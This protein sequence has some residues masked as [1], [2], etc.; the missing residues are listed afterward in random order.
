M[1]VTVVATAS[2]TNAEYLPGRIRI[3]TATQ[4]GDFIVYGEKISNPDYANGQPLPNPEPLVVKTPAGFTPIHSIGQEP[5]LT[6]YFSWFWKIAE[7]GDAGAWLND[8]PGGITT[9]THSNRRVMAV[10]RADQPITGAQ[11]VAVAPSFSEGDPAQIALP[12]QGQSLAIALYGAMGGTVNPRIANVAPSVEVTVPSNS[13]VY[14][15][16]WLNP[17]DNLTLDIDDEGTWNAVM[18]AVVTFGEVVTVPVLIPTLVYREELN[19]VP[20]G[21]FF[22]DDGANMRKLVVI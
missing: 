8:R 4:A 22:I 3:P 5:L 13:S 2:T 6:H 16:A 17:Q 14:L 11:V 7:A 15:D 20:T 19:G 12:A 9:G 18:G 21:N 1:P 10:F